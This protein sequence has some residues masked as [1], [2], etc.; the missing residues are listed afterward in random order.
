MRHPTD[1]TVTSYVSAT[2]HQRAIVTC[3]SL[4][5]RCAKTI[6]WIVL[7]TGIPLFS[8]LCYAVQRMTNTLL[9]FSGKALFMHTLPWLFLPD[10][11]GS[12]GKAGI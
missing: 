10:Q 7:N 8:V 11:K 1:P 12:M 2:S 5:P 6:C 3:H 9:N 4:L